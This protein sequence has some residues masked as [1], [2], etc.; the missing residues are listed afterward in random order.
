[1]VNR[2]FP[3]IRYSPYQE[4]E[5]ENFQQEMVVFENCTYADVLGTPNLSAQNPVSKNKNREDVI[6]EVW[7]GYNWSNHKRRTLDL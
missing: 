3:K 7:K 5:Y 6:E 1:M 4:K 2:Y